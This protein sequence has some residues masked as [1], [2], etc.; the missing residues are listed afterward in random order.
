MKA[1]QQAQTKDTQESQGQYLYGTS[2]SKS[3]KNTSNKSSY[4]QEMTRYQQMA[5]NSPRVQEAAYFQAMAD[6]SPQVQAAIQMQA[7][8]DAYVRANDPFLSDGLSHE[9][10]PVQSQT[11][12]KTENRTGLPDK[13]K[14]GVENLSGF[15]MDDVRVHYN[16]SKPAQLNALAY[17]QGT[18]IHVASGQ[19]RHL[20]H[21]AWHVVQQ[22]QGR[23]KAT[24]QMKG[25]GVNNDA[26]LE[27]E[28]DVM[29]KKAI[30]D[31]NGQGA[32]HFEKPELLGMLQKKTRE[33]TT[34]LQ[35]NRPTVVQ[36]AWQD[37]VRFIHD[38]LEQKDQYETDPENTREGSK[39]N[40]GNTESSGLNTKL[41]TKDV[42]NCVALCT[43]TGNSVNNQ[44]VMTHHSI[45]EEA[46]KQHAKKCKD[47]K[48]NGEA[49]TWVIGM[50]KHTGE[51]R[52]EKVRQKAPGE[53]EELGE[54]IYYSPYKNIKP[55]FNDPSTD[56][57]L[58]I[59]M[60]RKLSVNGSSPQW[61]NHKIT[62][63]F[64]IG[65]KID[66]EQYQPPPTPPR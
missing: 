6:R 32:M 53:S 4:F 37:D 21:E 12:E 19:E 27:R 24:A 9:Q 55:I 15:S 60:E 8:A 58:S 61:T 17:A 42:R 5:D 13:L 22:K 31:S 52:A 63:N 48:S 62:V 23:V 28:A 29:G 40:M 3:E 7:A 1:P 54:I 35:L 39:V 51:D 10:N 2:S 50:N 66:R 47:I 59:L 25:V 33:T 36:C 20:P 43:F 14:T 30:R 18:D 11:P 38:T 41:F 56:A 65:T 45:P 26:A 46:R 57:H 64:R 49:I 16:S 44:M 34:Q